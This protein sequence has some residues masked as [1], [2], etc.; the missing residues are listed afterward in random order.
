MQKAHPPAYVAVPCP[1]TPVCS[2]QSR[3]S[4]LGGLNCHMVGHRE[5][6]PIASGSRMSNRR[7]SFQDL[8]EG[9]RQA[10][11]EAIGLHRL[12]KR[13]RARLDGRAGGRGHHFGRPSLPAKLTEGA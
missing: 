1:H 5:D 10:A 6:V 12:R 3:H 11:E 7:V 4:V 8:V 13:E 9:G 2:I